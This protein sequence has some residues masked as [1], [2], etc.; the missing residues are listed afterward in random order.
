MAINGTTAF[1]I[2][3]V[4]LFILV[5]T[6]LIGL[7]A[8]NIWTV[9][10]TVE[11]IGAVVVVL[12]VGLMSLFFILAYTGCGLG[13]LYKSGKAVAKSAQASIQ[14]TYNNATTS[15]NDTLKGK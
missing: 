1:G 13:S 4:I 3:I 9:L 14:K 2:A 12:M 11:K 15:I 5:S 8:T 7:F 6:I 10:S